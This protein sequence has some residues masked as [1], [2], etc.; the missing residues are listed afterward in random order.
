M[1]RNE[2]ID[3]LENQ[4]ELSLIDLMRAYLSKE[5]II[6][7]MKGWEDDVLEEAAENLGYESKRE[8]G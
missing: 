3:F 7:M 8:D 4:D 5:G 1:N 6:E 2:I